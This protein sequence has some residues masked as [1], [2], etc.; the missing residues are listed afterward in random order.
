MTICLPGEALRYVLAEDNPVSNGRLNCKESAEAI[1]L[2]R[3]A[4]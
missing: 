2:G 4:R 1:V 3:C